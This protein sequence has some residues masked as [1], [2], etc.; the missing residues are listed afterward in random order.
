MSELLDQQ[1]VSKLMKTHRVAVDELRGRLGAFDPV[2]PV[3]V[4]IDDIFLLR[5][6]LSW[7]DAAKAEAPLRAALAWRQDNTRLT[8]AA[9]E[10]P[11]SQ[12]GRWGGLGHALQYT[13]PP[14]DLKRLLPCRDR[15]PQSYPWY[16]G[17][18]EDDEW[19][20]A[21]EDDPA[22]AGTLEVLRRALR[23]PAG[24]LLFVVADHGDVCGWRWLRCGVIMPCCRDRAAGRALRCT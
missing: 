7:K 3:G 16:F 2:D 22:G 14:S 12:A 10:C 24:D 5:F 18:E 21:R 15:R 11:M 13:R 1:D 9:R 4:P 20:F 17:A 23:L 6:V 19:H 8:R